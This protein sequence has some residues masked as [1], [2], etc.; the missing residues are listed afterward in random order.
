MEQSADAAI[1][2]SPSQ[3]GTEF[4]LVAVVAIGSGLLDL[5]F[6]FSEPALRVLQLRLSVVLQDELFG[7]W[8]H[9]GRFAASHFVNQV[10]MSGC[11]ADKNGWVFM[12]SSCGLW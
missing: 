7:L 8:E 1:T 9:S 2:V 5:S 10:E 11:G 12:K 6:D 3:S 4:K